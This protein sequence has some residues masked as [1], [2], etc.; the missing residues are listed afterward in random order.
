[1]SMWTDICK[2]GDILPNM[3]RC[4]LFE[5]QQVAIFRVIRAGEELLFAVHNYCPFSE[6]NIISRG[7]IGSIDEHIVV[8]SP[9]YKQHFNLLNGQCLQDE[10]VSIKTFQVRLE[11]DTVQLS[12]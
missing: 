10:A 2:L 5:K 12:K 11:G 6:A 7:I 3:G 4:A 8:A 1:M 9:L